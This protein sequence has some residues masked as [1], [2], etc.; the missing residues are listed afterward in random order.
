[1]PPQATA[2]DSLHILLFR[3]RYLHLNI[4]ALRCGDDDR[5][6]D[7]LQALTQFSFLLLRLD[8]TLADPLQTRILFLKLE[9][10]LGDPVQVIQYRLAWRLSPEVQACVTQAPACEIDAIVLVAISA[11]ADGIFFVN[12]APHNSGSLGRGEQTR[13][14]LVFGKTGEK[15]PRLIIT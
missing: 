12:P 1:M 4:N 8:R 14:D 2:H 13:L 9:A 3:P 6:W 11:A 10:D 7:M 5:V 15:S